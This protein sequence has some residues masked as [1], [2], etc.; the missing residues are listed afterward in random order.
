MYMAL[1][2][3]PFRTGYV[4]FS[5]LILL[6]FFEETTFFFICKPRFLM[7]GRGSIPDGFRLDPA[8]FPGHR[9]AGSASGAAGVG[10][11]PVPVSRPDPAAADPAKLETRRRFQRFRMISA[12]VFRR[13]D[14]AADAQMAYLPFCSPLAIWPSSGGEGPF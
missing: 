9:A 14:T 10:S 4:Y 7:T 3:L 11:R 12:P 1:L 2:V 8:Q 5:P 13:P 6:M